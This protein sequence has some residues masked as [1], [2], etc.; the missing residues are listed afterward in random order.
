MTRKNKYVLSRIAVLFMAVWS[1]VAGVHCERPVTLAETIALARERSV[2]A[3]VAA[4]SLRSAYWEYRTYRANLLPEVTFSG[5]IPSYNKRYNPWQNSDGSYTFLR[6]DNLQLQGSLNVEQR[7]W[8]TGGTLSLTSSLDFIRQLS[9]ETGN[10]YMSV[11]VAL[12][13]NQPLFGVNDVKWDRRIE[14]V[15]YR[16]AKATYIMATEEVAMTAIR[17][18][19]TLL[20]ARETLANAAQNVANAEKMYEAAKVQREMGRIS[21]NDLLQIELNL[22]NSRSEYMEGESAVKSAMFQ[23]RS[24]LDLPETDELVPVTPEYGEAGKVDYDNA[25]ELA[26]ANNPLALNIRRRQLEADYEVAKAKGEMRQINLFAQVGFTGTDSNLGATYRNLR[27]N[28]IVEVGVSIPLVDW[29]KRKGKVET[30]RSQRMLTESTLR[31]E[32]A[33]FCQNL[34]VLVERFNNQQSQL[35]MARRADEIATR[36]YDS[37]V[38]TFM[39]GRL[40]AL[41]LNNSQ[42]NKDAARLKYLNELYMYWY[43]YYQLRSLTLWDFKEG[44]PIEA[45]FENVISVKS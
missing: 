44:M 28:Q 9:G 25:L 17:Y 26:L 1:A 22:I 40:S 39:I 20:T 18:F 29:G 27:D 43:F 2:D 38:E 31:K 41:D 21:G 14:P 5:T 33:D 34:F 16:E 24:F 7:V 19:F 36:R 12:K 42:E 15:R 6:D 35:G 4:N 45:D 11:P 13:F 8:L 32:R 23:L 37:S 30:A 3:E 10:L